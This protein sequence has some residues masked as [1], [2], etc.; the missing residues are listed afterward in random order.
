M[1]R[2]ALLKGVLYGLIEM[3]FDMDIV[4]SSFYVIWLLKVVYEVLL[5][6]D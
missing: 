6:V 3:Y 5:S 2:I 4:F 1:V